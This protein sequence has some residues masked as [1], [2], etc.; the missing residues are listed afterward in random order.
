MHCQLCGEDILVAD[1]IEHMRTEHP[2]AYE[3]FTAA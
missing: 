1:T 3:D 2:A